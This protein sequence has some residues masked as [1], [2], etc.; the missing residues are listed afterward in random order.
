MAALTGRMAGV[1]GDMVN[2]RRVPGPAS[3]PLKAALAALDRTV[4]KVGWFRTAHYP[5]GVPVAYVASIHEH[6]YPEG[7]IPPRLGMRATAQEK[8]AGWRSVAEQGAKKVIKG[9][10]SP[11]GLME[12]LGQKSAGDIRKHIAGP[13]QPPLKPETVMARLRRHG[14]GGKSVISVT[15]AKPLVDTKVLLNTLTNT[16]ENE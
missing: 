2:V 10:L 11:A 9:E 14:G 5:S 6:G 16:V 3:A 4:G 1:A 8:A 15:I 13:I 7:G 12:L